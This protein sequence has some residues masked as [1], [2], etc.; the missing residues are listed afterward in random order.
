M[1]YYRRRNKMKKETTA[2]ALARYKRQQEKQRKAREARAAYE[3]AALAPGGSKN[4]MTPKWCSFDTYKQIRLH[5]Q[6]VRYRGM[7]IWMA[8]KAGTEPKEFKDAMTG[9]SKLVKITRDQWEGWM[10]RVGP[11]KF[12]KNWYKHPI[13]SVSYEQFCKVYVV[14]EE[15]SKYLD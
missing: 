6:Q 14:M 9:H 3:R 1:A 13:T 10:N 5:T 11:V 4:P 15:H 7:T 8:Y 12:G 2:Q